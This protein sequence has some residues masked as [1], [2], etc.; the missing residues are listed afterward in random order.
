M[1]PTVTDCM[2]F[3]PHPDDIELGCAGTLIKMTDEGRRVVLADMTRG[4][5]STR[6][7]LEEREREA[8]AARGII[9]AAERINLGLP[10]GGID[11]TSEARAVVIA[12]LRTHR[13]RMILVPHERDRHP[14]HIRA[15]RLLYEAA[16]AS[17]LVKIDDGR[18]PWRPERV[19]YYS[20]WDDFEPTFIV[21]ITNAYERKMKAIQAF[22][23]QFDKNDTRYA[24]TRLTSDEF[25]W[26]LG[27]RMGYYGSKIGKS[28]GEPFLIRGQ[29]EMPT[30]LDAAYRTF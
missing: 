20:L 1:A 9:G 13:P 24:P 10:D 2:A 11:T 18:E 21:D 30:P 28:Y 25:A 16:F 6:G 7:T 26:R 4:E 23:T 5:L 8:Q 14:D 15:S 3:G 17:G 19:L 12:A 22:R 27:A 29:L